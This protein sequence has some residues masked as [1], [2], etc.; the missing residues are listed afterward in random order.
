M[1]QED[2][3]AELQK[4]DSVSIVKHENYEY[5]WDIGLIKLDTP[6][7]FNEYVQPVCLPSTPV[8][9]GTECVVTGWGR[10]SSESESI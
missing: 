9:D 3:D 10:I 1:F 8:A 5:G 6:L 7:T 2:N 4:I